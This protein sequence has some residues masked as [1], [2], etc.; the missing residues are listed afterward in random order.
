MQQTTGIISLMKK[1]KI[2]LP[3][4]MAI[5]C[6]F[7]FIVF[8]FTLFRATSMENA[9]NIYE[10]MMGLNG[11]QLPKGLISKG[12]IKMLGAKVGQHLTNEDNLN[13]FFLLA[14]FLIVFKMPNTNH[15]AKEF[16]PTKKMAFVS[17]VLL[18]LSLLGLNRVSEFIYFNF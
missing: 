16:K 7:L 18:V 1:N 9:W 11:V 6:S 3:K 17:S 12:A 2:K 5:F 10:G 15:L 8:I 14:G 4:N 13:L